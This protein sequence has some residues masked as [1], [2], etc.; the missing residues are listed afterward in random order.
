MPLRPGQ[1]VAGFTTAAFVDFEREQER[2]VRAQLPASATTLMPG[3][4]RLLSVQT[5][6]SLNSPEGAFAITLHAL[7]PKPDVRWSD[8]LRPNDR[9]TIRLARQALNRVTRSEDQVVMIGFVDRIVEQEGVEPMSGRPTPVV[10][11]HGTDYTKLFRQFRISHNIFFLSAED[12]IFL[13]KLNQI[14]IHRTNGAQITEVLEWINA[15]TPLRLTFARQQPLFTR[16]EAGDPIVEGRFL[17][18]EGDLWGLLESIASKPF[19]ELFIDVIDGKSTLVFRRTPFDPSDFRELRRH[20]LDARYHWSNRSLGRS[21]ADVLNV[22]AVYPEYFG[23]IA[24]GAL[25]PTKLTRSIELFGVRPLI[26]GTN[27][28]TAF[29]AE[30]H[31]I[32]RQGP[33]PPRADRERSQVGLADFFTQLQGQLASWFGR[34]EELKSGTVPVIG[35]PAIHIGEVVVFR[36]SGE[37]YYVEGVSHRWEVKK[38]AITMLTLTRGQSL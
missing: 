38:S 20:E 33:N 31:K 21:D 6:K 23:S 19:N 35:S 2:V 5:Q 8:V 37:I 9:V 29:G 10:T 1:A 32:N 15:H 17:N 3:T 34:N 25:L 18:Y 14:P 22:F 11:V 27:L 36:D 24:A 7:G 13:T 26:V 28:S 12:P 16:I 4:A 30:V